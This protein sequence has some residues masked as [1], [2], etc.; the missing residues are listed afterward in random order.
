[1]NPPFEQLARIL[2]KW[3][4]VS[5]D[6]VT[7]D[8]DLDDDLDID[9]L[10][11]LELTLALKKEFGI[12]VSEDDVFEARTVADLLAVLNERGNSSAEK[13]DQQMSPA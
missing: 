7:P 13:P 6:A 8:A 2:T 11:R 5:A 9:S 1:M 3:S 4:T 12:A 10:A